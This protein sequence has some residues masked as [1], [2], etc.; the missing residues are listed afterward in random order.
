[1]QKKTW[2]T[3]I[4]CLFILAKLILHFST[5][6]NYEL[7]RDEMLYFNMADHVSFGYASVPPM[8]GWLAWLT[9]LLFGYSVFGIRFFPALMGALSIWILSR[10][11]KD[12]DG[13][14]FA[15]TL[16][17]TAFLLSPGFL[18]IGSL[19]TPNVVEQTL[20][21]GIIYVF[22]RLIKTENLSLW[23]VF[24][25]LTGLAFLTKY[26]VA[27][28]SAGLILTLLLSKK[29]G[30]LNSRF[31]FGALILGFFL[32]LPN[33]IWQYTH[34][35]PIVGHMKALQE[36]QL[37]NQTIS[38]FFLDIFSLVSVFSLLAFSGI[39]SL[40]SRSLKIETKIV[41][42]GLVVTFLLFFFSGGKGYYVLGLFP[43]WFAAGSRY[44]ESIIADKKHILKTGIVTFPAG[45]ALL[46]LPYVLP[47]FSLKTLQS[48]SEMTGYF[49]PNP[50][51]RWEDGNRRTISQVYSDMTGWK[52]LASLVAKAYES[53]PE[54]EKKN[55]TLFA[56]KN[57]GYAGA[58]HFYGRKDN[59]P[60]AIT[61]NDSYTLWAPDSIP[62]GSIIYI[63]YNAGEMTD[64][65][66]EVKE[67]G[68]VANEY[69]RERG[70]KV[71][72]SR[73]PK[74]DISE[75]YS[76]LARREKSVYTFE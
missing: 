48:Y 49:I 27:F 64:L 56:E 47:V 76:G 66:N 11:V 24:G 72:L 71:F 69:F 14:L 70:V 57:Y 30:L 33:L 31:F 52:E 63:Y 19:L 32:I 58:I 1:M 36:T 54:K 21:L 5:S 16:T 34:N 35:W 75:V 4:T 73:N 29:R 13:G 60:A 17:L 44:L 22:F 51:S 55:C 42:F 65:F 10:I 39:V 25:L 12:L 46:S 62:N 20:W 23:L 45:I 18:L 40:F 61:F 3:I 9:E 26:S 43:F 67:I 37:V 68:T 7:H 74:T 8:I 15:L 59:L 41:S 28:R 38:D 6:T 2:F 53:L 50:F